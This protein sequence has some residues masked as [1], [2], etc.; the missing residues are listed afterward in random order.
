MKLTPLDI[1]REF[2]GEI[3]GDGREVWLTGF[4]NLRDAG[5]SD[6]SFYYDGRYEAA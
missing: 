3:G 1:I 5:P 6:L 4:A 2:G